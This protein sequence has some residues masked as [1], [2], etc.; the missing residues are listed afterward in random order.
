MR[1]MFAQAATSS[2]ENTYKL[3]EQS[4]RKLH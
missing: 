4:N 3:F 1:H 2:S